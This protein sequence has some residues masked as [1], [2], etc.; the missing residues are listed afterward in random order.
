[1]EELKVKIVEVSQ[2][3]EQPQGNV[4]GLSEAEEVKASDEEKAVDKEKY[5]AEGG[6]TLFPQN[7]EKEEEEGKTPTVPQ[8]KRRGMIIGIVAAMAILVEA[9]I[10]FSAGKNL[11]PEKLTAEET[12]VSMGST[13]NE[14]VP[15][16]TAIVDYF[17]RPVF[18]Q[19][20]NIKKKDTTGDIKKNIEF[21]YTRKKIEVPYIEFLDKKYNKDTVT[22]DFPFTNKGKPVE[23]K[24]VIISVTNKLKVEYPSYIDTD[25]SGTFRV[26]IEPEA[27]YLP[28]KTPVTLLMSDNSIIRLIIDLYPEKTESK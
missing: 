2:E 4:R 3:K 18:N 14:S 13:V 16:K 20:R 24:R 25:M 22:V 11:P 21:E 9:N 6:E 1:M 17:I 23:V 10:F 26:T 15:V 19:K 28:S 7:P 5:V 8:P 27:R 12:P